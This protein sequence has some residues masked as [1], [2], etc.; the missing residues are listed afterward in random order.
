MGSRA[1]AIE[2][3]AVGLAMA[4]CG[5]G[6]DDEPLHDGGGPGG[7]AGGVDGG[8]LDA[9]VD[10]GQDAAVDGGAGPER[11]VPDAV[12]W[13]WDR[14]LS[15]SGSSNGMD[16]ALGP[17]GEVGWASAVGVD[18]DLGGGVRDVLGQDAFVA[19]YA[20]DGAHAWDHVIGVAV[21]FDDEGNWEE[22][23]DQLRGLAADAQGNVYA[24]GWISGDFDFG[25]GT[26]PV[27][28]QGD[29]FVVSYGPDGHHRWDHVYG[30]E[31]R[32]SAADVTVLSTG[33]PCLTGNFSGTV[34]FGGG[35]RA[36]ADGPGFVVCLSPDGEHLWDRPLGAVPAAMA[37]DAS[38][39][40]T[41]GGAFSG[42]IL[43]EGELQA[44]AG[45]EDGFLLGLG[46]DGTDR[47]SRVLGTA[48]RDWI[49]GLAADAAG[50]VVATGT[51]AGSGDGAAGPLDLGGG[52]RDSA[53]YADGFLASYDA[54]GQH[55]WDR[56]FG[57][58][59]WDGTAG[60]VAIDPAGYSVLCASSQSADT[61]LDLGGGPTASIAVAA[62]DPDGAFLWDAFPVGDIDFGAGY[63]IALDPAG[64]IAVGGTFRGTL[65]FGG[66]ARVEADQIP[67]FLWVIGPR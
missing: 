5:G 19:R 33:G 30:A 44:S 49:V 51:F 20:A 27:G 42:S 43:L 67:P 23:Y 14:V 9:G 7:D 2:W 52:P 66:G 56:T 63:A 26:R 64:R 11:W 47:W 39:R 57:G 29:A 55:L 62:Y 24:V 18:V 45:E 46:P 58:P 36:E 61:D 35:E 37:S 6:G 54:D 10:G 31:G 4:A 60:G 53:G 50:H 32:D 59:G 38:D 13:G 48:G 16:V 8:A 34:D 28:A 12:E 1:G 40:I 3:L 15:V 21:T 22:G 65:D 25:G 41:V 17:D